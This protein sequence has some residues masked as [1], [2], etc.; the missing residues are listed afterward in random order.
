MPQTHQP[1]GSMLLAPAIEPV[2]PAIEPVSD[3]T[4]LEVLANLL[5]FVSPTGETKHQLRN[6]SVIILYRLR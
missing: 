1:V 6:F 5:H 3:R 2:S 4:P